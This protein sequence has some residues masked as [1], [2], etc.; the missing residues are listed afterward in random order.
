M[1]DNKFKLFF[2]PVE[3]KLTVVLCCAVTSVMSDSATLWT[4]AHQ[5]PPSI[6][7]YSQ[8][9]WSRLPCPPPGDLPSSGIEPTSPVSP[10]LQENSLLLSHQVSP[11]LTVTCSQKHP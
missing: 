4:I 9:Y 2:K 3:S 10:A 8:E 5:A 7:F 6:G 1:H 11:K